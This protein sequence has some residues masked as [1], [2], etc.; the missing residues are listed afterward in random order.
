MSKGSKERPIDKEAFYSNYDK[1]FGEKPLT[2][3][4]TPVEEQSETK[5]EN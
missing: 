4:Q 3:L 5:E 2:S 1:I